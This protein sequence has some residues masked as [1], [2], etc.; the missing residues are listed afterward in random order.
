MQRILFFDGVC[1]LCNGT[2]QWILRHDKKQELI[3][4]PLQ[5]EAA[6]KYLVPLGI[7]PN[8]LE[9]MIFLENGVV[10]T[11][12]SGVLYLARALG[13]PYSW[14]FA[15]MVFPQALRDFFYR[16]L[17]RNRYNGLEKKN[18]VCCQRQN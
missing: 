17:A 16:I 11:H 10:H 13:A 14:A 2:V 3:F 5:S 8:K 18:L 6:Q 15:L 7:D 12:S 4:A 9:S 1:N